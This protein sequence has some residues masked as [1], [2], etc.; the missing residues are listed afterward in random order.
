MSTATSG[1][2]LVNANGK[3]RQPLEYVAITCDCKSPRHMVQFVFDPE[4][5]DL[6]LKFQLARWPGFF[7]RIWLALKYIFNCADGDGRADCH[8]DVTLLNEHTEEIAELCTRANVLWRQKG[9]A[10]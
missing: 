6:Y 3:K 7:S 10:S 1:D 2:M 4:E 5:G 8:W 9:Y